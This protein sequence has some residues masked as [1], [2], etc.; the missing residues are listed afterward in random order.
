MSTKEN[1]YDKLIKFLKEKKVSPDMALGILDRAIETKT[2]G[3]RFHWK[4]MRF[5]LYLWARIKEDGKKSKIDTVRDLVV[6][7]KYRRL[8]ET[9]PQ[10]R[11]FNEKREIKNLAQLIA[12]PRQQIYFK[13]GN[14]RYEGKEKLI[15]QQIIDKLK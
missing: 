9:F 7:S 15:P 2:T 14:F 11:D 13:E 10:N 3:H 1:D 8:W 5:T 12:E 4:M 6:T